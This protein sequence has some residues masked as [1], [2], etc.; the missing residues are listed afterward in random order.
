MESQLSQARP[1]QPGCSKLC[2]Q[3]LVRQE[4]ARVHLPQGEIV[5]VPSLQYVAEAIKVWGND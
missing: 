2:Q 5:K 4:L 1:S 3:G